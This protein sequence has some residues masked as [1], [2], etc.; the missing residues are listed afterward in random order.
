MVL[1][2][3]AGVLTDGNTAG[4]RAV[5]AAHVHV[6]HYSLFSSCI[7]THIIFLKRTDRGRASCY[8]LMTKMCSGY[9]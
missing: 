1:L 3:W 7:I 9:M 5:I 6:F 4:S 8:V 2:S